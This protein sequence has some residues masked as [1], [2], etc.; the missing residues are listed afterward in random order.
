MT[1]AEYRAIGARVVGGELA[2]DRYLACL[3][4]AQMFAQASGALAGDNTICW[5]A[6]KDEEINAAWLE[7]TRAEIAEREASGPFP[8]DEAQQ[9]N[10]SGGAA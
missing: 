4:A 3:N 6:K 10:Q 7:R 1:P 2:Y 8:V 9:T 5:L